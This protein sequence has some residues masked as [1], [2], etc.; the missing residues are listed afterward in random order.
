MGP[1]VPRPWGLW[2]TVRLPRGARLP[3]RMGPQRRT[4]RVTA[5]LRAP[6]GV[7]DHYPP[8]ATPQLVLAPDGV[9][10]GCAVL[11]GPGEA[12]LAGAGVHAEVEHAHAGDLRVLEHDQDGQPVDQ[13]GQGPRPGRGAPWP[14]G[15]ATAP[16]RRSRPRP[17]PPSTSSAPARPAGHGRW[18]ARPP[19]PRSGRRTARRRTTAPR[20][21]GC[22]SCRS[23]R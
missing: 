2:T 22:P 23:S 8:I 21:A 4:A 14:T 1:G 19:P 7:G 12:E 9:G 18:P 3:S 15:P 10:D 17:P 13:G 6:D 16:T 11:G 5:T 20:R